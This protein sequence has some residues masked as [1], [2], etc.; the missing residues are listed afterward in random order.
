MIE[1]AD[2]TFK[3]PTK[4]E[5]TKVARLGEVIKHRDQIIAAVTEEALELKKNLF[6][7]SV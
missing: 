2:A 5:Q 3:V 6:P 7:E 4:A 1:N